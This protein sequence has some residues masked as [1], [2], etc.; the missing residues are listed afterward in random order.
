MRAQRAKL[1]RHNDLGRAMD[2]MLKRWDTFTRGERAAVMYTLIQT[3]RL[4]DANPQ[5]WLTDV[6][7]ASTITTSISISFCPGIGR[8]QLPSSRPENRRPA[9]PIPYSGP[10]S[11]PDGYLST[12]GRSTESLLY[13]IIPSYQNHQIHGVFQPPTKGAS[14][15]IKK[16]ARADRVLRRKNAGDDHDY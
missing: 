1:S 6:L 10:R 16:V 3:A 5:A 2:Y 4:N 12:G 15:F 8:R 13:G 14:I 9:A 11:P 7:T